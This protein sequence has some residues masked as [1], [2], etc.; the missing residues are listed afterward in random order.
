MTSE[1]WNK[2]FKEFMKLEK[3]QPKVVKQKGIIGNGLIFA[4]TADMCPGEVVDK[5]YFR[6]SY[7]HYNANY[8]IY[9]EHWMYQ[10]YKHLDNYEFIV[11]AVVQAACYDAYRD[12]YRCGDNMFLRDIAMSSRNKFDQVVWAS[13][14]SY[15]RYLYNAA[16]WK[17]YPSEIRTYKE[18]A[19]YIHSLMVTLFTDYQF[20]EVTCAESKE[21]RDQLRI[22]SDRCSEYRFISRRIEAEEG[23]EEIYPCTPTLFDGTIRVRCE[24]HGEYTIN[25]AAGANN[26]LCP[27]CVR[28][29]E[30]AE[31]QARRE[32]DR[33]QWEKQ[34]KNDIN[35]FIAVATQKFGDFYDYS[36]VAEDYKD[37][38]D[39]KVRIIHPE[40]G[41]FEMTPAKHLYSKT[42]YC[43]SHIKNVPAVH[44]ITYVLGGNGEK[45][46]VGD[47]VKY[48]K[49]RPKWYQ[50]T[51]TEIG[52][53]SITILRAD[54]CTIRKDRNFVFAA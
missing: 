12:Y 23:I 42:G 16:D 33:I 29:K 39:S 27:E 46:S 49:D 5:D 34:R 30:E 3:I 50:G 28:E 45:I 41:V 54:G 26:H 13:T 10:M 4:R 37:F 15:S 21:E 17:K 52:N 48:Q 7:R 1:K 44:D 11:A 40:Y 47:D 51:V 38:K 22:W 43:D 25:I 8:P 20:A 35:N 31:E 19:E 24:K 36:L 6:P 53:R 9:F 14:N 32:W 18:A 2:F